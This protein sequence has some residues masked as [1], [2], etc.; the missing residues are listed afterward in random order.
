MPFVIKFRKKLPTYTAPMI[1]SITAN[2]LPM[3]LITPSLQMINI[4]PS[5]IHKIDD[6]RKSALIRFRKSF[7]C[8]LLY[9]FISNFVSFIIS[10]LYFQFN[11]S[12]E[13]A[14]MSGEIE[15]QPFKAT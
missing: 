4:S 7:I 1:I 12:D 9:L 6:A 15:M 10:F 2:T 14:I 5:T 11:F 8:M 3:R 13:F